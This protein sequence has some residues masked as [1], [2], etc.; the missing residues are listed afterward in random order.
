MKSIINEEISS[1]LKEVFEDSDFYI[2]EIVWRLPEKALQRGR[3][4]ISVIKKYKDLSCE[5]EK[6]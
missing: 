6:E 1:K 2:E 5:K 3:V 4:T